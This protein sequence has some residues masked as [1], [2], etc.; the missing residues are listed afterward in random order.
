MNELAVAD[1]GAD[2]RRLTA[3]VARFSQAAGPGFTRATGCRLARRARGPRAWA[4]HKLPETALRHSTGNS[5]QILWLAMTSSCAQECGGLAE[6]GSCVHSGKACG[7]FGAGDEHA[8]DLHALQPPATRQNR[9][10]L[11]RIG[12]LRS[13]V[14]RESLGPIRPAIGRASPSGP[15]RD[16]RGLQGVPVPFR[17][18]RLRRTKSNAND[19]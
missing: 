13:S 4:V 15:A 3:L 9:V 8:T 2:W 17:L 10:G 14:S 7:I 16:A 12:G 1:K 19:V 18:Y 5:Q 11:L 6:V